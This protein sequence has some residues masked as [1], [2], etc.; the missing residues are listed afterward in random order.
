MVDFHVGLPLPF[1]LETTLTQLAG[2][3]RVRRRRVQLLIMPL[4]VLQV[5]KGFEADQALEDVGAGLYYHRIW[6]FQ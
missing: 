2:K 3:M 1:A 5:A 6:K 4:G